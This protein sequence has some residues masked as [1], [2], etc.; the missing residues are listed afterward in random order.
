[1]DIKQVL[2]YPL[3]SVRSD[4]V[5]VGPKGPLKPNRN[6]LGYYNVSLVRWE[7][8]KRYVKSHAVHRLVALAFVPNARPEA[9]EVN[10]KDTDKA[11]N[12][13]DNLE[14]LTSSE[15]KLHAT[16]HG[17]YPTLTGHHLYTHGKTCAK[18]ESRRKQ[19]KQTYQL[20]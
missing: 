1:M 15:N 10:H 20:T 14:W 12:R 11:N 13:P 19:L 18:R 7:G 4:G 16:A 17:L 9:T 2:N 8:G 3:Y 6:S 5:I